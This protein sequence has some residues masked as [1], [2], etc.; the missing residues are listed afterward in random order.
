MRPRARVSADARAREQKSTGTPG[1]MI[2][3]SAVDGTDLAGGA[4]TGREAG[5]RKGLHLV[6]AYRSEP[7]QGPLG[8]HLRQIGPAPQLKAAKSRRNPVKFHTGV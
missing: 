6:R 1:G 8:A 7:L 2:S 3:G 5:P 4:G